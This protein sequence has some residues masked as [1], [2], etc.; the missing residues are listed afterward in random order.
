MLL[1]P[2]SDEEEVGEVKG[3]ERGKCLSGSEGQG[4]MDGDV[5]KKDIESVSGRGEESQ[6]ILLYT[7]CHQ[8]FKFSMINACMCRERRVNRRLRMV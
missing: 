3:E 6:V 7:H 5:E 1:G 2:Y 4:K 8:A